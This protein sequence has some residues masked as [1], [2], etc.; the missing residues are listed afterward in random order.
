MGALKVTLSAFIE[1]SNNIH[2]RKFDY[3]KV[4]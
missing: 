3:S 4:D 1:R 2:N